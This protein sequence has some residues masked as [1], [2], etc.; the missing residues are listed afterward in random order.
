[1]KNFL[2]ENTGA[3]LYLG[4]EITRRIQILVLNEDIFFFHISSEFHNLNM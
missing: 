4:L 2:K 3:K 1:M